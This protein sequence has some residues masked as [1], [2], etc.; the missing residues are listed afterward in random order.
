[1][2]SDYDN[3]ISYMDGQHQA[4]VRRSGGAPAEQ[5]E[6]LRSLENKAR[7]WAKKFL[8]KVKQAAAKAEAAAGIKAGEAPPPVGG[9]KAGG[10]TP[11]ARRGKGT[12]LDTIDSVPSPTATPEPDSAASVLTPRSS[13]SRLTAPSSAGAGKVTPAAKTASPALRGQTKQRKRAPEA[14]DAEPARA[15][16]AE[17]RARL[18]EEQARRERAADAEAAAQREQDARAAAMRAAQ[19]E[20]LLARDAHERAA[21]VRAGA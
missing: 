21:Q 2:Q 14:Q 1:M 20:Q 16:A 3:S 19:R 17:E 4:L 7:K 13:A 18:S 5:A 15:A 6:Q 11:L 10:D 8:H 12:P 9:L